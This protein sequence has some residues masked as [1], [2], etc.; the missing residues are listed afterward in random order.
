MTELTFANWLGTVPEWLAGWPEGVQRLFFQFYQTFVY[1]DRW[2]FF[3]NGLKTTFLITLG[4]LL[5]GV[6]IG[7]LVAVV[8]S[9]HDSRRAGARP[10]L[11]LNFFNTVCKLYLTVIRGTPMMVQLLIM[12]YVILKPRGEQ[13]VLVTAIVAFGINSGAYV[14]EIV[15]SGIMS[16]SAG[17]MEAGRSLGL[18]YGKTMWYIIIPQ[19]IKNILP[20]LGNEMITLIKETSI[21]TV[22]AGKDLTKAAQVI[23]TKTNQYLVPYISLAVIYLVIV[24]ILTKLLGLLERRLRTSDRR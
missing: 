14:A 10:N 8:R 9:A 2:T 15:R 5:L 3:T 22:I 16:I 7:V 13:A 17:Q 23:V 20:A 1:Q 21:V 24:L 6:L 19:A 11:V 12:G 18:T 4:A